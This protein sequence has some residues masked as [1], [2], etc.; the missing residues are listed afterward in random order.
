MVATAIKTDKEGSYYEKAVNAVLDME[1]DWGAW[2]TQE[3]QSISSSTWTA[4]TG[5]TLSDPAISANKTS[6][7][8]SGG[9]K[10]MT[11]LLTNKVVGTTKTDERSIRIKVVAR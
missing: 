1:F 5:L 10:G 2:V 9:V 8:F 6:V 4:T 11:Y 7:F 3:A